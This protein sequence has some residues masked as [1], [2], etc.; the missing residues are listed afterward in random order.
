MISINSFYLF[1]GLLNPDLILDIYIF[2]MGSLSEYLK[3]IQRKNTVIY[4]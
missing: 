2:Q 3:A 4:Q 1:S